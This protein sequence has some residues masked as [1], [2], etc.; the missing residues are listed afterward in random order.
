[1]NP[2]NKQDRKI[3]FDK[4]N[5]H[6]AYCGCE[7]N[8]D[9]FQVDHFKAQIWDKDKGEQTDNSYENLMPACAECNRYKGAWNIEQMR[10]WL[11]KS[12]KQLVKTQNLRILN[13]IGGFAI[14]DEP[15]KFYYEK[16]KNKTTL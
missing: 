14:S 9:K 4:F 13:R 15:I 8:F 12:K 10:E 1:M 6:C 16:H 2:K 5:G 11:E 3:I 7:L